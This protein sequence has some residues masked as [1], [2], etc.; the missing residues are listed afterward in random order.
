MNAIYASQRNNIVWIQTE[1]HT[2]SHEA[3]I[4]HIKYMAIASTA[5][6]CMYY[7]NKTIRRG[8]SET[9]KRKKNE[10]RPAKYV[11]RTKTATNK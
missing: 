3:H 11:G 1:A 7:T 4:K 5:T 6:R 8:N 2:Y 9:E 10:L